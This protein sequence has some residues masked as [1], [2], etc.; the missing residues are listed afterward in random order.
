MGVAIDRIED[1]HTK[2]I[3]RFFWY[4]FLHSF[5]KRVVHK[6]SQRFKNGHKRGES[7]S[8][9]AKKQEETDPIRKARENGKKFKKVDQA[10]RPNQAVP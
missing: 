7:G 5:P 10:A 4:L 1:I 2:K 3:K 8:K 9:Q 6:L